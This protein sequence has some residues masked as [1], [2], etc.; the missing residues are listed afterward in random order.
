MHSRTT[1]AA[2]AGFVV[3]CAVTAA[4]QTPAVQSRRG[5]ISELGLPGIDSGLREVTSPATELSAQ[6]LRETAA[7]LTA[8]PYLSDSLIVKFRP[9]TSITAQRAMIA[10]VDGTSTPALSFASFDIVALRPGADPEAVAQQLAAQPDVEYAQPRYVVHPA[11]IP[12]DPL[13]AQQWNFPAIDMERAWDINPGAT[14]SIT[15]AVLD[16]G[17]AFRSGLVRFNTSSTTFIDVPFAAAPDLG[18]ADRFVSPRDFI[19]DDTSPFDLEGHGTH[20]TGTIGQLTNN[21]VGTAGMAFNVRI[22]PVKVIAGTWDIVLGTGPGTDD[23]V[24]R[25]IRFAV[26]NGAKV[27]NMSLGRTGPPAPAI[28]DAL[29]YAVSRGGFV[30][31]AAGNDFL[32]GNPVQRPSD[33]GPLYEGVVTVGAVGRSRQ[34]APYSSTG[35][36]VEIAAPGGDQTSSGIDGI[37]QQTFDL[38]FVFFPGRP[39]RFDVFNYLYAQGTSMATAHVSGFAALLMQQGITDPAAVE[40]IMKQYAT[41]LGPAGRDDQYGSGLIN[42]RAALRGMGLAR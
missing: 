39:P 31:V 4:Q 6:A 33:S 8:R 27:L 9:G 21:S 34:R 25:G 15:V 19:W 36:Y 18:G 32:N 41:D 16:T 38:D 17:V 24:A 35:N 20:V 29:S 13:Y 1:A 14:S 3:L 30:A 28:Q 23:T 10:L 5:V 11:F 26:D 2:L 40:A 37:L 12:N 22:M 42:V 7:A